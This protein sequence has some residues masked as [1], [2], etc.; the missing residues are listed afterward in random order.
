MSYIKN[1]K[2]IMKK[3]KRDRKKKVDLHNRNL[4]NDFSQTPF[5][6]TM[7]LA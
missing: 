2:K 3:K 7:M 6:V 1:K 5:V 4:L